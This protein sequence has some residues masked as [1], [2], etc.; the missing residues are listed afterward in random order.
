MT[1]WMPKT[2]PPTKSYKPAKPCRLPRPPASWK[3]A[4]RIVSLAKTRSVWPKAWPKLPATTQLILI[5][6]KEWRRDD[7][8][9]ALV[10]AVMGSGSVVVFWPLYPE[11]AQRWLMQRARL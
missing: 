6:G 3:S 2:S 7:A 4:T 5:W 1:G 8:E 9:R 10:K 11:S